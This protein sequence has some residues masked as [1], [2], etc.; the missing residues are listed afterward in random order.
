LARHLDRSRTDLLFFLVARF[1]YACVGFLSL[2]LAANFLAPGQYGLY[3]VVMVFQGL[4]GLFLINP[5]GQYVTRCLHEWNNDGTI[6]LRLNQY[7]NV[8]LLASCLGSLFGCLWS[9]SQGSHLSQAIATAVCIGVMIHLTTW[10]ASYSSYLNLLGKPRHSV[11]LNLLTLVTG[12]VF[13][14]VIS[15]ITKSVF[16]WIAGQILGYFVGSLFGRMYFAAYAQSPRSP[17]NRSFLT[18]DIFKRYIGPLALSTLFYWWLTSGYRLAVE[19]IWGQAFLGSFVI[20]YSYAA[21]IMSSAETVLTQ[22]LYPHFFRAIAQP[23]QLVHRR[24]YSGMLNI[25]GPIYLNICALSILLLPLIINVFTSQAYKNVI[26]FAVIGLSAE[27]LR[28]ITNLFNL[29]SQSQVSTSN[30]AAS[31]LLSAASSVLFYLITSHLGLA[32][33]AI[34]LALCLAYIVLAISSAAFAFGLLPFTLDIRL[35]LISFS[36]LASF[37][38]YSLV[39]YNFPNLMPPYVCFTLGVF[40]AALFCIYSLHLIFECKRYMLAFP[41]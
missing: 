28:V 21:G 30:L 12:L 20:G 8:V 41:R 9:V 5:V 25:L 27:S 24:A 23:S 14:C 13:S 35:W 10:S 37:G 38:L 6:R 1:L 39:I 40:I 4:A 34:P 19:V 16:G 33:L 7:R 29:S 3:S 17:A 32:W 2:S 15:Y 31:Y 22:Y 36:F 26:I 11:A 18:I